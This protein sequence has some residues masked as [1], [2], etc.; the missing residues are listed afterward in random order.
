MNYTLQQKI[1]L[2]QMLYWDYKIYNSDIE[3]ILDGGK[4]SKKGLSQKDVFIRTMSRLPWYLVVAIWGKE[5]SLSLLDTDTIKA[6]HSKA[7][8]EQ[9]E[10]LEKILRGKPLP[11]TEWSSQLREKLK[12]SILSN[13]WYSSESNIL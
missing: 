3:S 2:I 6:V 4:L 11:I 8:R 10:R 7:R 1:Q 5:K 12:K 9:L 13:R